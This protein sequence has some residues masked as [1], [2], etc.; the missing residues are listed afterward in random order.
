MRGWVESVVRRGNWRF[1]DPEA[2]CQDIVLRLLEW[3]R[4]GRVRD[5]GAFRK[6]AGTIAKSC[7]VDA[8]HRHRRRARHETAGDALDERSSPAT[9]GAAERTVEA[10]E[11]LAALRHV[12]Q[13]L[14][15]ACRDLWRLVYAERWPA[16]R[17]AE[18]LGT[19]AGNV[20]VRVHRCLQLARSLREELAALPAG[21]SR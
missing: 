9:S 6:L 21:S 14:P 12:W 3:I 7:C 13:R 11:R 18:Q 16:E 19:T 20:R 15:E 8:Y 2:L 1:E 10:R 17:V 4:A 5:P